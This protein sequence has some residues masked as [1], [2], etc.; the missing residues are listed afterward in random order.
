MILLV[1]NFQLQQ[2]EYAFNHKAL[3]IETKSQNA[4]PQ[5]SRSM[6]HAA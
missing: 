5:E 1:Q 4:T 3:A 2:N 6:Q